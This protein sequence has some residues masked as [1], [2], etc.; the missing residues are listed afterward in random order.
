MGGLFYNLGRTVGPHIRRARWIWQSVAGTEADAIKLENDVGRDLAGQVRRQ[1]QPDPQSD[2]EEILNGVGLRLGRCVAN[3]FR[4]FNFEAVQ[5]PEPNAFALPG[6]FIFV[7]R[8]LVELCERQEDE[9]AFILGHE[10]GHIVRG[11]AMQ[12]LISSSAISAVSRAVAI[13]GALSRWL[14]K[15]GVQFLEST[16]SQQLEFEADRFGAR[17]AASA[18][19][20]GHASLRLLARLEKLSRSP[21]MLNL[22]SYFSSHPD[23]QVRINNISRILIKC[24]Q[25]K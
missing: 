23:Y 13:H 22:G 17:L 21:D 12:R 24:E 4:T 10:M 3:R 20:D 2:T 18:G 16:Y 14:Q 5:G 25:T 11:H 15:V 9:I 1:L 19:Y 8:S 7:T 6:G